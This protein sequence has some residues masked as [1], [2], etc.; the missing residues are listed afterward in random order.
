MPIPQKKRKKKTKE[1][2]NVVEEAPTDI[3]S[4]FEVE[5]DLL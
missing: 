5:E 2:D 3:P 1:G 4:A